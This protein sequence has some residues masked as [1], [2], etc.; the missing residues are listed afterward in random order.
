MIYERAKPGYNTVPHWR[1]RFAIAI[2]EHC[3]QEHLVRI[4]WTS[5]DD[6]R[7]QLARIVDN[8]DGITE[9]LGTESREICGYRTADHVVAYVP[10]K[11]R[12]VPCMRYLS[13]HFR[14][15]EWSHGED[16]VIT[17]VMFYPTF[18]DL[19]GDVGSM[20]LSVP[21][22]EERFVSMACDPRARLLGNP[23]AG[24][25]GLEWSDGSREEFW[26]VDVMTWSEFCGQDDAACEDGG[27]R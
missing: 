19:G 22:A 23:E 16:S 4:R 17:N 24:A 7:E 8:R 26:D 13:R 21:E 5:A 6:A 10:Q 9:L 27:C 1:E 12:F 15:P 2:V 18:G 14:F 25:Y 11:D 3:P 20:K